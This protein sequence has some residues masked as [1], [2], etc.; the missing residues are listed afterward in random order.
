[1]TYFVLIKRTPVVVIDA[2]ESLSRGLKQLH[3]LINP[4]VIWKKNQRI[5]TRVVGEVALAGTGLL[6]CLLACW[7][8]CCAVL[9]LLRANLSFF[10]PARDPAMSVGR[11]S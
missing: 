2:L 9:L 5:S 11:V 10:L 7:L 8:G 4:V 6:G 1:M 3:F